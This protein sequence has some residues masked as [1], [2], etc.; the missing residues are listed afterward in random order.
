MGGLVLYNRRWNVASDDFFFPAVYGLCVHFLWLLG[1]ILVYRHTSTSQE[2]ECYNDR[3]LSAY[4]IISIIVL[5]FE[6]INDAVTGWISL[7][8][9]VAD[10]R[11]RRHITKAIYT[12]ALLMII[13]FAVQIFGLSLILGSSPLTC[14]EPSKVGLVV[15]ILIGL[16]TAGLLGYFILTLIL[17]LRSTSL[18][19]D[20]ID[21]TSV[22][23]KRLKLMFFSHSRKQRLDAAG[24][25]TNDDDPDVLTEVARIFAEFMQDAITVPSDILVGVVLLRQK[26]RR[27]RAKQLEAGSQI[28]NIS[29]ADAST[30]LSGKA[31]AG[32][33]DPPKANTPLVQE[34]AEVEIP[35][36]SIATPATSTTGVRNVPVLYDEIS[37]I[38]YFFQYAE[39]IYGLPLYMLTNMKR[40]VYH[41]CCPWS[42]KSP[43]TAVAAIRSYTTE[44]FI[45]CLPVSIPIG[46][47]LPHADLV[48]ISLQGGLFR[49]PFV[50]C[51][52]HPRSTI[53]IAVR[54]TLSTADILVDL[55]CDLTEIDVPGLESGDKA[56]THSGMFR[57]AK[58]VMR[59][60]EREGVL[61]RLL[62][63]E[64]SKYQ[65]YGLVC[66][67]HSLGGGVACLLAFLLR[68][69]TY[70]TARAIC[71]SPPGCMVTHSAQGYFQ[72]FCTTVVLGTDVVPRLNRATVEDLKVNVNRCLSTCHQHKL[73]VLGSWVL[74]DW[75]GVP[76]FLRRA[77]SPE[78][79]GE[80]RAG[81][82]NGDGGFGEQLTTDDEEDPDPVAAQR[83]RLRSSRKLRHDTQ[84][85]VGSTSN[86]V[87]NRTSVGYRPG[88]EQIHPT[89]TPDLELGNPM[90]SF[91]LGSGEA[92]SAAQQ[93]RR[94]S[95]PSPERS[96]KLSNSQTIYAKTYLPGKILYFQKT[97]ADL[98]QRPARPSGGVSAIPEAASSAADP[99]TDDTISQ[100]RELETIRVSADSPSQTSP[101]SDT[102]GHQRPIKHHTPFSSFTR[103]TSS[104]R[105]LTKSK[106]RPSP[107]SQD[108]RRHPR[109][110][111]ATW[112]TADQFQ[113]IVISTTMAGD[114]MPN[115]MAKVFRNVDAA[116]ARRRRRKAAAAGGVGGG[117]NGDVIIDVDED[118]AGGLDDGI[119]PPVLG[120]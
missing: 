18:D 37:D 43:E 57:T 103:W 39:C 25:S 26:Q 20:A 60:I 102:S 21:H 75:L 24:T 81:S 69:S 104:M 101:S 47:Q 31:A 44:T 58:N 114:H 12:H 79:D 14:P 5:S 11:P 77:N 7:Q 59:E 63:E 80:D 45:P 113:E 38:T 15:R 115:H 34:M 108:P 71:Y 27:R 95:S 30:T 86:L 17:F 76:W 16:S 107:R 3:G 82:D 1:A 6:I 52:D 112:A 41:L 19:V 35:A 22:W 28:F 66:C 98:V 50:V 36:S 89:L 91:Q 56:H 65:S 33:L 117:A 118:E 67:G 49:S 84:E 105:P 119:V 93:P 8:G 72:Q 88:K 40:G 42:R 29:M 9:T 10:D 99:L 87:V 48:H 109:L 46:D 92:S 97:R 13:E 23:R 73:R 106:S 85:S 4:L 2:H 96:S 100:P 74:Q 61:R 64:G 32:L 94:M 62:L 120:R 54:G 83:R 51:F 55:N 70:P 68:T 110:Y 111:T 53:V 90:D 116:V 78:E